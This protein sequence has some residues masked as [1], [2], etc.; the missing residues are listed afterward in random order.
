MQVRLGNSSLLSCKSI[1]QAFHSHQRY[2]VCKRNVG[3]TPWSNMGLRGSGSLARVLTLVL[4]GLLTLT[5]S[6]Q[7]SSTIN[8]APNEWTWVGGSTAVNQPSV[9]GTQGTPASGNAPGGTN[10]AATW[11]DKAGNLWLFGGGFLYNELW[12]Y[13]PSTNEWTWMSGSSDPQKAGGIYN[14]LG[15]PTPYTTPGQRNGAVSW[16]DKNGNFWLFGGYGYIEEL[17][18][19]LNDLWEYSPAT[20][21]WTWIAGSNTL[22]CPQFTTCGVGAAYGTLRTPSPANAPGGR[23]GAIGW[24]DNNG[25]LW[26]YGGTGLITPPSAGNSGAQ[27]DDLWMFDISTKQWTWMN[28]TNTGNHFQSVITGARGV[29]SLGNMPEAFTG[30][31]AWTDKNGHFWMFGDSDGSSEFWEFDP[32]INEWTWM[33]GISCSVP[34]TVNPPGVYGTLG[35]PAPDNFPSPRSNASTWTDNNGNLW[36]FG[37]YGSGSN[38][39]LGHLNDLWQFNPSTG[40]WAW[41]GGIT[42]VPAQDGQGG[43]AGVYG[44]LGTPWP[45]NAPG[46]RKAVA[47]WTGA[48]GNLWLFGGYGFGI[49]NQPAY[50]MLGALN[51]LWVYQPSAGPLP[52]TSTPV[53]SLAPGSYNTRQTITISDSTSGTTIYYTT[54]GTAP[55]ISSPV[56]S[57]PITVSTSQTLR[58]IA[59][60]S[61]CYDSQVASSSYTITNSAYPVPVIN[62]LSPPYTSSPGASFSLVV[63]GSGFTNDS[64]VYWNSTALPS[65]ALSATQVAGQVP[66][67]AV[68]SP[69]TS[70]IQVQNPTP[71]GGASG[72][73]QFEIDSPYSGSVPAPVFSPA[74]A[75]VTA[76]S[77]ASFGVILPGSATN[78]SVS[79][80]NLPAGAACTYSSL[81][82]ALTI[83]TS[84]TTPAGSY[85]ITTVFTETLP[86][87]A[88]SY[89]PFPLFLFSLLFRGKRQSARKVGFVFCV[90]LVLA[91]AACCTGC[92]G[93]GGSGSGSGTTTST[94]SPTHQVTRSGVV[95]LIVH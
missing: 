9:L 38:N 82:S 76:G 55:T 88:Y 27:L 4:F 78:V 58:A 69:G 35:L 89:I 18:G 84:N 79:C 73:L 37:G 74:S 86:V 25:N 40:E 47:T 90:L 12:R 43:V 48:D 8:V 93:G 39:V 36:L 81:S 14:T 63:N 62:S 91:F 42:A 11:T 77:T 85:Q 2:G 6:S 57:G 71:G 13:S 56:Y 41:M 87:S 70:T 46:G 1:L 32:S 23:S 65:K 24:T 50:A 95:N 72:S 16:T 28:G 53:F 94:P 80:L 64:V 66:A 26:L 10:N 30:P 22:A 20:N 17:S 44:A 33:G 92:G 29:P 67:S 75:T 3:R 83:T 61:G 19:Y 21:Q 51:D 7:S 59:T 15:V 54:D 5:A 68:V 52:T 45:G 60:A 31:S 49:N 34:C